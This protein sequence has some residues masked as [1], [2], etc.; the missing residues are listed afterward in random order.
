M[1]GTLFQEETNICKTSKI[2]T[3]LNSFFCCS[4]VNILHT[5][6]LRYCVL[7]NRI[8]IQDLLVE[9]LGQPQR[10]HLLQIYSFPS[11]HIEHL[12]KRKHNDVTDSKFITCWYYSKKKKNSFPYFAVINLVLKRK[13]ERKHL[14]LT[15]VN[16]FL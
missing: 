3:F 10:I 13:N 11:N 4:D 5:K 14:C 7:T 9:I 8:I 15:F 2:Q 1:A 12:L 16:F 6:T